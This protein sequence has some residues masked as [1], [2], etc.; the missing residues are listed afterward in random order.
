MRRQPAQSAARRF[1]SA[2]T[3]ARG[4]ARPSLSRGRQG[5]NGVPSAA[6][7]STPTQPAAAAAKGI[8]P[9]RGAGRGV[10]PRLPG[11]ACSCWRV[12]P[13][14][15]GWACLTLEAAA[16]RRCC[17]PACK[18]R[19]DSSPWA[20][21]GAPSPTRL[22]RRCAVPR[23]EVFSSPRSGPARFQTRGACTQSWTPL[24]DTRIGHRASRWPC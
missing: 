8:L 5:R 17:R 20:T 21:R 22:F 4:A 10:L 2:W 19:G 11:L 3:H 23:R 15:A 6:G 16:P 9:S 18:R 12:G 14:L 1:P 7:S 13:P 24:A